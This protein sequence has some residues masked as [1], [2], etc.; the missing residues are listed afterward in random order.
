MEINNALSSILDNL[1]YTKCII[2]MICC[3]MKNIYALATNLVLLFCISNASFA[4]PAA[5]KSPLRILTWEGYVTPDDLNAVNLLLEEQDYAYEAVVIEPLSEGA[6]Q[7]FNLIRGNKAD[8]TFLTLFFIKMMNEQTSKLLQGINVD[9]PR[10]NN[11]KHLL[12]EL[13]NIE[14]GMS[15]PPIK[16]KKS[17]PLYIP[18]GGGAYGFYINRDQVN[19]ASIPKSIKELWAPQW[20]KVGSAPVWSWE[21]TATSE[22]APP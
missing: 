14:M 13:T 6:E 19:E 2:K 9:S 3:F 7:M 8:V 16:G 18:W 10:L 12:P 1:T 11:Y 22:V 5:H 15:S 17:S 20:L 21:Q 4:A